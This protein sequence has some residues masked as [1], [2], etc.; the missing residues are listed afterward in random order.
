MCKWE[1]FSVCKW[2][3]FSV[4]KWAGFSVC[5]WAGFS[6][7]RSSFSV[8]QFF[9]KGQLRLTLPVSIRDSAN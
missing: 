1:E 9:S 6:V 4:C 5:K 2:A 7:S 3:G 8:L